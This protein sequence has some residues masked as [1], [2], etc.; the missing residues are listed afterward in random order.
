LVVEALEILVAVTLEPLVQTL[1]FKASPQVV[2]EEV[3]TKAE[4]LQVVAQ[5]EVL[6]LHLAQIL[7]EV[8]ALHHRDMRG[9]IQTAAH[10][11]LL[12][13]VEVVQVGLE[14]VLGQLAQVAQVAQVFPHQ[15]LAPP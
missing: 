3:E 8:L 12:V 10:Q 7:V 2:V 6:V 13:A 14:E 9:E 11:M 4:V 15:S 5:E 1:F